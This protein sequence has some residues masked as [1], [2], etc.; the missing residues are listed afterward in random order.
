[1][2]SRTFRARRPRRADSSCRSK[3]FTLI[4]LLVVIAI[5]AI[6]ASLLLPALTKAKDRAKRVSCASN[7]KQYGMAC[8]MY[9]NDNS[10]MLPMMGLTTGQVDFGGYWPWDVAVATVNNLMQQ[11]TQRHIFFC[12]SFNDHDSDNLWGT[13]NGTDNPLGYNNSG[14]RSTGYANT[15]PG[16]SQNHGVQNAN[17]NTNIVPRLAL[18]SAVDRVVLA[19]ATICTNGFT[20][21]QKF[22][23]LYV[24]IKAPD[25][26]VFSSPHLNGR[27]AAGGNLCMGD[28]HVEW[29]L[30]RDLHWRSVLSNGGN[31]V[32]NFWW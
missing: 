17:V 7:L 30:L 9:A 12:P 5:I 14:Y 19:D 18:G 13:V 24:N 10:G 26:S 22:S 25:G 2:L 28:G 31:P 23:Y 29:R 20:E 16:G 32:P 11:G 3:A 8:Q 15:F 1:M 4:E 6:L 21:S 27:L